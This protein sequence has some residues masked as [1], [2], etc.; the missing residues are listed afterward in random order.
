[1]YKSFGGSSHEKSFVV[2]SIVCLLIL[3][4]WINLLNHGEFFVVFYFFTF[5]AFFFKFIFTFMLFMQSNRWMRV[6]YSANFMKK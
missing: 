5:L 6:V 3:Q 2:A 1:M 4:S